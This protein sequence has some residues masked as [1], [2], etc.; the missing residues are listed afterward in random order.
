MVGNERGQSQEPRGT[1]VARAKTRAADPASEKALD[2]YR[3]IGGLESVKGFSPAAESLP[4]LFIT[5]GGR[6]IDS[7][8]LI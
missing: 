8:V 3:T 2:D 5:A 4:V 6:G 1:V 7:S